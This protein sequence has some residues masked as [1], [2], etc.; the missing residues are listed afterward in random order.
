LIYIS[1]SAQKS[2]QI[3]QKIKI[4]RGK[5]KENVMGIFSLKLPSKYYFIAIC[6]YYSQPL[7]EKLSME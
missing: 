2:L 4:A 1:C 7:S 5:D 3:N 6:K